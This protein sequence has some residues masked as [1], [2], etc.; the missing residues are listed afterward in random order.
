MRRPPSRPER[1][2]DQ[3]Q[4]VPGDR[5]WKPLTSSPSRRTS[6]FVHDLYE[7]IVQVG[8]APA[9]DTSSRSGSEPSIGRLGFRTQHETLARRISNNHPTG[10]RSTPFQGSAVLLRDVFRWQQ[11]PA[12]PSAEALAQV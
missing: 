10:D 7:A 3:Y 2:S 1:L 4:P 6:D 8:L 11:P 5:S 12:V 9:A